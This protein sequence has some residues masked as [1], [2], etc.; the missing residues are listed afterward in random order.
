M[1]KTNLEKKNETPSCDLQEAAARG[2][3]GRVL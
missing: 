2:V 3:H 1:R